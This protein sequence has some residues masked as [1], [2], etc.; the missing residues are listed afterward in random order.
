ML[1]LRN[2]ERDVRRFA[3]AVL[4]NYHRRANDA[5][6]LQV[7]KHKQ[8]LA[9]KGVGDFSGKTLHGLL[10]EAAEHSLTVWKVDAVEYASEALEP[11]QIR[12]R[13]ISKQ[14]H[15]MFNYSKILRTATSQQAVKKAPCYK[16]ES[17][18]EKSLWLKSQLPEMDLALE[19]LVKVNSHTSHREGGKR[20]GQLLCKLLSVPGLQA[21]LVDSSCHAPHLIFRSE[22]HAEKMPVALLGHLDTVFP[23]GTFEGY[24]A[25]GARRYGPGVYDMKGGLIVMA[26]ALKAIARYQSLASVAPLRIVIVS[27]EEIGSPESSAI[28]RQVIADA[29]ACLVFEPGRANDAIVTQRKG[30]G[31]LKVQAHG[32]AAHAGNAYWEGANAIW[33]LARF[34]ERAQSLSQRDAGV[35]VSVGTIFGGTARNTVPARA[36]ALLDIRA[37]TSETYADVLR[38]LNE[39]GQDIGVAGT[40][41]TMQQLSSRAPMEKTAQSHA[42]YECYAACAK[43]CGLGGEE[44]QRQGGGSD[45]NT[46]AGMGIPAI[47][48]LGPRGGGDHTHDEFIEVETLALRAA[49]LAEWLVHGSETLNASKR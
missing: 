20:V 11:G 38:Q 16:Y 32:H 33:A 47:D 12:L 44:A 46:A 14:E 7:L 6:A 1:C 36:E 19:A 4:R 23:Q 8:V 35:T 43:R 28:I 41:L 42:L 26:W 34:V 9:L 39:A 29:G 27:D 3:G 45:A 25:D 22:G 10:N 21:E 17:M 13:Y 31:S 15:R 18:D 5:A 49:A 24:R 37:P 40:H 2:L 30:I 48:A